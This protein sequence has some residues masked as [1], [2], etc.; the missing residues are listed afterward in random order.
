MAIGVLRSSAAATD[1][2]LERDRHGETDDRVSPA[3]VFSLYGTGFTVAD[4]CDA[5]PKIKR[6]GFSAFQP[7]IYV[8]TAIREWSQGASRVGRAAA[9]LALSNSAGGALSAGGVRQPRATRS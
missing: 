2:G 9:D 6:L 7:E 4:F 5:L 3:F 8:A 1:D